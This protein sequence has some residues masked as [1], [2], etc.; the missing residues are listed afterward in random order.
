MRERITAAFVVLALAVLVGAGTVRAFSL[1]DILREETAAHLQHEAELTTRLIAEHREA[2][3]PVDE[4]Y[5]Q[6]LVSPHVRLEYTPPAGGSVVVE[7]TDFEASGDDDPLESTVTS[8]VGTVVITEK[9]G[10]FG[11]IVGR[12]PVVLL[13]VSLL[14]IA[15]A[16]LVGYVAARTLSRPF[17]KLAEA[18]E[19]L[20]RGRFD[21][22]LPKTRIPEAQEIGKA[23][24]ASAKQ[25]ESRLRRE[26]QF[27]EQASHELRTPITALRL[28]LE[29]LTLRDDVPDDAKAS[30]ARSLHTVDEMSA[31]AGKLVELARGSLVE[32][33]QVSLQTL[34]TQQAQRWADRLVD[35]RRKVSASAEGNLDLEFTPG[36]VEHVLDL[37]LDDVVRGGGKEPVRLTFFAEQTYLRV[38]LPAGVIAGQ[39]RVR[40]RRRATEKGIAQARVVAEDQGGRLSGDGVT[41][42]LEILLPRR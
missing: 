34:A 31:S 21:L 15:L 22:D 27:A 40:G 32:G 1:R 7:G 42:D 13:A 16:G 10:S 18:A 41:E 19:A 30:A 28:E 29:E 23:L 35:E 24:Y 14:I 20:G 3:L 17:R 39:S 33:A 6:D 9:P 37:V 25:L 2:E 11:N 26:R 12:D 4:A 36:P 5:L 38:T 8:D